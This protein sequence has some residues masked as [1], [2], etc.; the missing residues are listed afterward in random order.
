[1][2]AV[3]LIIPARNE[4]AGIPA[5][6][7]AIR[8]LAWPELRRVVLVDNGSTDRTADL[9]RAAGLVVVHEPRR[10]YGAA[11]LAGLDWIARSTPPDAVA[12]L[13]ADLSDDPAQLPALARPVLAGEADLAIASRVRLAEPG[14]LDTHQRFGNALACG[15]MALAAGRRYRDLGP[16]RVIRWDAL[17]ALQMRDRTWGWTVEMQFKAA[18]RGLRVA[19]IDAPYRRRHAGRSKISGS[20]IGSVRAGA[21]IIGAIAHLWWTENPAR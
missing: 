5:L 19:E 15:L 11:C 4:A 9:A 20:V 12:F 14:A 13:D 3:D 16:M 17:Q 2:A 21:K 8:G 7:E 1:M 10:G 6:V 18:T